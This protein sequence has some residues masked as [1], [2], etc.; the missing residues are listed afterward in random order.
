[1]VRCGFISFSSGLAYSLLN[2]VECEWQCIIIF[3][4]P[5][6]LDIKPGIDNALFPP[7]TPMTCYHKAI[8]I[9]STHIQSTIIWKRPGQS[10]GWD[11]GALLRDIDCHI[12]FCPFLLLIIVMMLG[13]RRLIIISCCLLGYLFLSVHSALQIEYILSVTNAIETMLW[14]FWMHFDFSLKNLLLV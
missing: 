13:Y 9:A 4:L 7:P 5:R 12:S 2:I 10:A 3:A 8:V 14:L 1:M 6:I 11:N